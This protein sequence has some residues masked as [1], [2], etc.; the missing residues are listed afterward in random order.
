MKTLKLYFEDMW[1]YDQFQ[2]NPHDNYFTNLFKLNFNVV[3]DPNPDILIFSVF[4]LNNRRYNCKKIFFCGENTGHNFR[5][6]ITEPCNASLSQ[7]EE[8]DKNIY[9]PLWGLFVNW[10]HQEQPKPLPSNPTFHCDVGNI[11][12][13]GRVD[14][15]KF[16]AFINNNPIEDRLRMFEL[17]SKYKKVDSYGGLH[18]NVGGPIRGSEQAKMLVLKDY[19]FTIAFENSYHPGYNTEKIIQPLAVNTIPLYKGG[20]RV[21]EFFNKNKIIF[22]NNFSSLEEMSDYVIDLD[23][24]EERFYKLTELSGV[25]DKFFNFM[26]SNILAKLCCLLGL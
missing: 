22:A 13:P 25:T 4:G 5:D 8:K 17:L 7:F 10:F 9:F 16:C 3:I 24:D 12:N 2:F 18:N 1:G 23:K 11:I 14:K 21:L 6:P 19:K 26:S 15:N 20:E